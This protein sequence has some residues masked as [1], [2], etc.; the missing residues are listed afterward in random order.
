MAL[1]LPRVDWLGG[2]PRLLVLPLA[3]I[4]IVACVIELIRVPW[5]GA[6]LLLLLLLHVEV[7]LLLSVAV[8]T[9]RH[10]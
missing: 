1:L 3:A 5:Y 2:I 10:T 4:A 7:L 8:G 9:V 6:A